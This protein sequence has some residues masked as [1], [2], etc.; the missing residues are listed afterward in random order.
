[1]T[2]A[3]LEHLAQ[4]APVL[5][6]YGYPLLFAANLAEGFGI[7]MPGQTLLMAG[8]VMGDRIGMHIWVVCAVAWLATLTGN[9]TGYLIGRRGGT[10]LLERYRA[11]NR[12]VSRVEEFYRRY[13]VPLVIVSRFVD[14]LRQLTS[15]VAG[16]MK[17]PWWSF[18]WSMAV[19]AT[20]W[21][22]TWGLGLY[23]LERH[24]HALLHAVH[25]VR[26]YAVALSL[27]LLGLLLYY[28]YRRPAGCEN[29][30]SDM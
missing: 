9:I 2:R 12:H 8:A 21:V 1:M 26:P 29:D 13:G 14:G 27:L 6:E 5:H 7:P 19:G 11:N 28:L 3:V 30:A 20:L 10:R 18:F 17:M 24:L 16:S 22:S 25:H 15:L 4:Y 23:Y